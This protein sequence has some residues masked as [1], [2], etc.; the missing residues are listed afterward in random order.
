[1]RG[2]AINKCLLITACLLRAACSGTRHLP[3][4]EKLY[5][6]ADIR[7]ESAENINKRHI[8]SIAAASVR[9]APD[10]SY[11]GMRPELWMYMAAGDDPKSGI[12]KWLKKNGEAPVLISSIKPG[13]TTAI[14]DA[15]LFNIGI[16]RS[17]TESVTVEKKRT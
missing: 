14:I 2:S 5:T 9:P 7:I 13:V 8:K 16:F 3:S 10:K 15:R 12:G 6:G 1:M 11:L 4:G 17:Y